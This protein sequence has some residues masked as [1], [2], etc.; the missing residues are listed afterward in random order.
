MKK[1]V[2]QERNDLW[3]ILSMEEADLDA[4]SDAEV[5]NLHERM[6]KRMEHASP[7]LQ[8]IYRDMGILK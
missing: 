4:M 1:T 5:H 2:R 7:T 3:L 6:L 8:Q